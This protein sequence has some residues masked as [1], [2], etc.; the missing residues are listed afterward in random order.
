[1]NPRLLGDENISHRF[2]TACH[3]LEMGF[4]LVHISDWKQGAFRSVKDPALL[5]TLR[6]HAMIL[7]GFDRASMLLHAATLTRE[8]VG[9]AGI[10]LFRRSVSTV[11]YGVQAKLLLDFWRTAKDWEWPDRLEYLPTLHLPAISA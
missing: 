10:I 4:P 5:M 9:H 6:D 7:I 1:M 3:Q 11:A 2:V 8:G